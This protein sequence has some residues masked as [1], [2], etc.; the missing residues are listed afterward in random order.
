MNLQSLLYKTKRT[1]RANS[2]TLLA[3]AGA[4]GTI[5]T[6]YLASKASF[7]AS[8]IIQ[9]EEPETPREAVELVWREYIPAATV[10]AVTIGCIITS[11]RISN[12]R[13]AAAVAA[14]SFI[15]EAFK[16]YK[17]KVIEQLGER[18]EQGIRDDI[19][20]DFVRENNPPTHE[21]L[22]VGTGQVLCCELLTK[23]YFMGD[24]ETLRRA[25]NDVN[26][27]VVNSLYVSLSDFYHLIGL[28]T[29]SNSDDVGWDSDK[30]MALEFSTVLTD[31]GKP[32]LAFNYNYIK[33]I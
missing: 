18:K 9:K 20:Q 2:P 13:T 15:D 12:Q 16:G 23:R 5:A 22:M 7:K 6:A 14:Y 25:Q 17:E 24:M 27:H 33:P 32:C 28:S 10:G 21:I 4:A 29:T 31:D 1:V 26:A 11:T 30:L 19:A 3:V 8:E